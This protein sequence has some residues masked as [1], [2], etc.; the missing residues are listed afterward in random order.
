MRVNKGSL[1]VINEQLIRL[2]KQQESAFRLPQNNA[3]V[4]VDG[5]A[6]TGK[7]MLALGLARDRE[8]DGARVLLI[9]GSNRNMEAWMRQQ[10]LTD[11]VTLITIGDLIQ[12]MFAEFFGT[13]S[14]EWRSATREIGTMYKEASAADMKHFL[15]LVGEISA[16]DGTAYDQSKQDEAASANDDESNR[17]YS[18]RYK[19]FETRLAN[20]VEKALGELPG[21]AE[22]PFDYLVADEAQSMT[23]EGILSAANALLKGGWAGGKWTIFGDFGNQNLRSVDSGNLDVRKELK[24]LYPGIGWS[25]DRLTVN[26]RNTRQ[27]LDSFSGLALPGSYERDGEEPYGSKV[28]YEYLSDFS[29]LGGTLEKI[30][31]ELK[32]QHVPAQRVVLLGHQPYNEWCA[33]FGDQYGE[34]TLQD[35]SEDYG[36]LSNSRLNYC[37]RDYFQGLESEVVIAVLGL[38]SFEDWSRKIIYTTL[39]RAKGHLIIIAHESNRSRLHVTQ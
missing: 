12:T 37:F 6:G 8:Q 32:E 20:L 27:I 1:G 30:V 33:H 38:D 36:A 4:L 34:W 17:L 19:A 16:T 5:A 22:P 29:A 28:V 25:N 24:R 39:S 31:D 11:N 26:C 14:F 2:T 7:S 18:E 21:D 3:R 13:D 23:Q 9:V 15:D 10:R 35:I